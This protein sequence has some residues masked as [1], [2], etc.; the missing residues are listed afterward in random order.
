MVETEGGK[1]VPAG[2]IVG[3]TFLAAAAVAAASTAALA[4]GANP[5]T[6]VA[7]IGDNPFSASVPDVAANAG[8]T[9]WFGD[10]VQNEQVQKGV[11]EGIK[12]FFKG[13][14]TADGAS[15]FD[16]TLTG[17]WDVDGDGV[18]DVEHYDLDGDGVADVAVMDIDGD[19]IAD[20][21]A[22]DTDGDGIMDSV[23]GFFG[24]FFE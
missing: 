13:D 4:T 7:S 15:P 17:A 6:G 14:G 1:A 20:V 22:I 16:P 21:A 18:A 11:K 10:L 2:K 24:S 19:G 12:S 23:V 9:N 3:L 5:F 8:G